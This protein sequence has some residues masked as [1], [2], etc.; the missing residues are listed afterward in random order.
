[1]FDK[2]RPEAPAGVSL[3]Y[4]EVLCNPFVT[5]LNQITARA[6]NQGYRFNDSGRLF[7]MGAAVEKW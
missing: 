1:M 6:L 5:A 3:F 4:R 7:S 2:S